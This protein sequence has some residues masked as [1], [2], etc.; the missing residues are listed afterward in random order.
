M[1]KETAESSSVGGKGSRQPTGQT[2]ESVWIG[3]G[4]CSN[5]LLTHSV[6][7]RRSEGGRGTSY[8]KYLPPHTKIQQNRSSVIFS[9]CY[10]K[11]FQRVQ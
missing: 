9:V 8:Y 11:V 10:C 5:C 6:G 7:L 2:V 4:L 3:G 1:G